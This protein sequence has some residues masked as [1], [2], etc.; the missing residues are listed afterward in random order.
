MPH[1]ALVAMSGFRV[2]EP[3]MIALG[4]TLPGLQQRGAA[5]AALPALGLLTLAALNPPGWESSYHEAPAFSP[6]FV[7]EVLASRP[8]LV[9]ISALTASIVDAYA[10][11]D[12][13]RGEGVQVVIGGLHVTSMPEEAAAHADAVVV[14]DGEL[15]WPQVLADAEA[16]ILRPRYR[17][18]RPFDLADSPVPRLDLLGAKDRPRYTLQTSRGCPLACDFCAASRTL[19]PYRTKPAAV[20][21]REL[22]SIRALR[23][24]ACIEL[25]DDNTFVARKDH[26]ELLGTLERSGTRWFTESDWRLGERPEILE[27]LADAGCVQVLVGVETLMPR[28]EGFGA[29]AAPLPRVMEALHAIQEAGVAVIG[30]FVVGGDGEDFETM[31][32]LGEFLLSCPL[33]DVQLTVQTPFP[34]SPLRA[35]LEREG[36]LLS[37]RGWESCTLFDVAYKPDRLSADQLESGFRN[38]VKYTFAAEPTRRREQIRRDIWARRYAGRAEGV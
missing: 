7:Q 1:V 20:I 8:R 13:I 10:L 4:M 38:L 2:R 34:G 3:E 28:H 26:A 24:H 27:R 16:G 29:K 31:H 9:A 21:E 6:A 11:A 15:V 30:C 22:D 17:G 23:K 32:A 35:R 5:I 12:A 25:A 33:A 18:V 14:G 37:D 19:G 36:R